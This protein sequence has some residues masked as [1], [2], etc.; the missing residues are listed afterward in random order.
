MSIVIVDKLKK[1][2]IKKARQD[3]SDY[4][5]ITIDIAQRIVAIGG[6]YHADAEEVLIEN[7]QSKS[8]DIWG[9][10]YS[11]ILHKYETNALVNIKAGINDSTEILDPKVREIFLKIA[12]E[13]LGEIKE[14]I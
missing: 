4:I 7:F 9:G 11:L 14:F 5:K 13:K 2:D 1:E 6:E 12:E 3:Y 8:G 10:G